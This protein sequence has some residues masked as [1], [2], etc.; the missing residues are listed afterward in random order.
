MI[1]KVFIVLTLSLFLK[2][3]FACEPCAEQPSQY[4]FSH[5]SLHVDNL[6][7]SGKLPITAGSTTP[8]KAFGIRLI[9]SLERIAVKNSY[10][11]SLFSSAYAN[12]DCA[13]GKI[14]IPKNT[15]TSIII[16]TNYKFDGNMD[17]GA[18]ISKYF[19]YRYLGTD[20]FTIQEWLKTDTNY[21]D[22]YIN[23]YNQEKNERTLDLMLLTPPSDA[24][25]HSFNIEVKL[26]NGDT[27]SA[28]TNVIL[29][30]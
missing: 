19:L 27:L 23:D 16:T 15:I 4:S 26:S 7:N 9:F 10:N 30:S 14:L 17:I 20:Y 21:P 2:I 1:Q 24:G 29:L 13:Y 25:L 18:D 22:R 6:D 3:I 8:K 11:M 5:T 28:T 12:G